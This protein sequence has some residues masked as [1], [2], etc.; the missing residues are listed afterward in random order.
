MVS[1]N[2]PLR[3][4]LPPISLRQHLA[5]GAMIEWRKIEAALVEIAKSWSITCDECEQTGDKLILTRDDVNAT[6]LAKELAERL[7]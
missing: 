5:G 4:Y 7:K 1:H 2:L 3:F 6:E